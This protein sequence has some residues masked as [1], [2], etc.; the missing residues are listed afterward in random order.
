MASNSKHVSLPLAG[1][2]VLELA[3][4]AP[5]PFAGMVLADFGADVVRVDRYGAS[6]SPDALCRGK[7]SMSVSL[8]STSGVALLKTLL[9]PPTSCGS[10][11]CKCSSK[12]S[13]CSCVFPGVW[14]AD[15]LIDPFRPGVLERLGLGPDVLL[16]LNPRLIIA[17]LTGFRRDGPYSKMAGHD[18]NYIALSGVLSLL[19]RKDEKPY[20]PANILA[21]FA[22][23]GMMAVLGVLMAVIERGRSGKGQVVEVD[24]VTGTRY[25]SSFPLIMSRPSIGLPMWD[26]P[27]GQNFLDGGAPWYDVYETADGGYMSLA[28]LENPFYSTFLRTLLPTLSPQLIPSPPPTPSQQMDRDSWPA[29]A[30]FLTTAFR[31]KTRAE[32]SSIFMGTDSC[33]V[34]VL[35][36]EE[37]DSQG[38]G[39]DEPGVELSEEARGGDGGVPAPAPRLTRTPAREAGSLQEGEGYF[40]SPGRDSRSVLVDAGLEKQVER[41]VREKVVELG[42]E[43]AAKAKL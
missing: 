41:L 32:W 43:E 23:G 7:R 40:L 8:K 13:T 2:R 18:L 42:D 10:S 25:V 35:G 6:F 24:M 19:G 22:G 17:R 31:S 29:L 14:R 21:D 15:V 9:S 11:A 34:P 36:R 30:T 39:V 3:G 26:Q 37:V 20:F 33:C 28:A 5:G 1:I 16:Q 38:V 27:R 12:G 4:L